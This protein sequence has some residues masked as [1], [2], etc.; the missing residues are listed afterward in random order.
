M[1]HADAQP[2]DPAAEGELF[3]PNC[4]YDLRAIPS[5]RCPE[6]GETFDRTTLAVSRIPWTHRREL[7]RIRAFLRT[8]WLATRRPDVIARESARPVSSKDA[9]R[10][11]WTV[12]F[13]AWLPIAVTAATWWLGW[14]GPMLRNKYGNPWQADPLLRLSRGSMD[15]SYYLMTAPGSL[16]LSVLSV[17]L[18]LLIATGVSSYFFYPKSLPLIRQDRA[19]AL[20]YYAAAPLAFLPLVQ[21]WFLA[22][23]IFTLST[24]WNLETL[25]RAS[26]NFQVFWLGA[27]ATGLAIVVLWLVNTLRIVHGTTHAGPAKLFATGLVLPLLW[28]LSAPLIFV[29]LHAIVGFAL[30]LILYW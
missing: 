5:N 28:L 26:R 19:V 9:Q 1:T 14:V 8:L 6:C 12:V 16:A 17:L 2:R 15:G 29:L 7:G 22:L 10:F 20:S 4:A 24:G 23:A 13:I 25:Y 21:A 3:C 11:R 27:C 30:I 18:W